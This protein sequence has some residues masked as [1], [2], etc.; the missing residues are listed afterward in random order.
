MDSRWRDRLSTNGLPAI[1]GIMKNEYPEIAEVV[2]VSDIREV[3]LKT[4]DKM[5][6]NLTGS[7][8]I[9][10]SWHLHFSPCC[11]AFPVRFLRSRHAIVPTESM[12]RK[13]F[14][15]QEAV[16]KVIRIE[17]NTVDLVV[18]GVMRDLPRNSSKVFDFVV[19]FAFL[20]E[21]G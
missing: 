4:N 8:P 20:K 16:G 5:I 6:L 14:G 17:Q 19:P 10:L 1:A 18:T 3:V 11:R 12:A 7:L 15:S 2:R 21:M 13:Y 9:L